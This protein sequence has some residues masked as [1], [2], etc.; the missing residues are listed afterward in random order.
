MA[1]HIEY[2]KDEYKVLRIEVEG[3]K[4]YLGSKYN[5]KRE[6]DE[7]I[8]SLGEISEKD[9]FIIFG[10]SFG[11]HIKELLKI[12][13][14]NNIL[15]IEL[16]KEL[17][18]YCKND[19][20]SKEILNDERVYLFEKRDD[21]KRFFSENINEGNIN[22]LKVNSYCKYFELFFKEIDK[23]YSIIKDE[24]S[25]VTLNRNTVINKGKIF[26]DNFLSN[27]KFFTKSCEVNILE[28]KYRNKPAII[29][30]AGPSLSK[31]IEHLKNVENTLILSGGRTLQS[32]LRIEA[33][34]SCIGIVDPGMVAYKLVEG[35]I[36]NI[37]CPLFFN[38]STPSIIIEKYKGKKFYSVQNP[39]IG[40]AI[41]KEIP[42]LYGGGS[43]AHSL[44]NLAVYMGCN[45]IIFIGQDLA[46]TGEQGHDKL[47]QNTWEN[48]TFDNFYKR[49]D[50]FYVEDVFGKP[51]RTSIQLD[52][53]RKNLEEIIAENKGIEFIN[54][55]E[56][57]ANIK[58]TVNKKLEDVLKELNKEKIISMNEYLKDRDYT[59]EIVDY[60]KI[61][62]NE[63]DKYLEL[64]NR[65][66]KVVE[67]CKINRA[68]RKNNEIKKNEKEF[69]EIHFKIQ[70]NLEK[71]IL[72]NAELSK[73]IYEVEQ[74]EEFVIMSSDGEEKA[75][76]KKIKK[77]NKL[78]TELS[79]V[80]G[81]NYKKIQE[82]IIDLET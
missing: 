66:K 67:K 81:E 74:C 54:A 6:I 4:K 38:D 51:V 16:N 80:I 17:I 44:T 68:L 48:L 79:R 60:L 76:E 5:Q 32:L 78:Y 56:G 22:F 28:N 41:K 29:V 43:I 26:L 63:C 10:F 25:R 35:Y 15:I 45:P 30:S 34:P 2:S 31:N 65:G 13:N 24:I 71:I 20:T 73:V 50:D 75:F 19:E 27:L 9:N 82:T 72:L 18:E 70:N 49:N 7:F 57:G 77:I 8:K 33:K 46:Y 1:L 36:N 64:C 21:I 14:N 11:E 12:I 23:Y 37:E 42:S 61:T 69:E 62:L 3:K 47:A 58:G 53:Y 40:K 59:G 55:T 52:I 39:F